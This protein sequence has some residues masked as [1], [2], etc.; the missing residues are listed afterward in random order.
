[1][2]IDYNTPW[3]LEEEFENRKMASNAFHSSYIP[4][5]PETPAMS[6]P[7]DAKIVLRNGQSIP[8]WHPLKPNETST[9][10][11]KGYMRQIVRFIIDDYVRAGVDNRGVSGYRLSELVGVIIRVFDEEHTFNFAIS[12]LQEQIK[13]DAKNYYVKQGTPA[14][15]AYEDHKQQFESQAPKMSDQ[16]NYLTS[17]FRTRDTSAPIAST[18]SVASLDHDHDALKSNL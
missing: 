5:R 10:E 12:K 15:K 4:L 9:N 14:Q 6:F 3:G 8:F 2:A 7:C 17:P 16:P 18:P 13:L 11:A 1:M